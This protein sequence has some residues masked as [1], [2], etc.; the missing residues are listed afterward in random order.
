MM[1]D[2]FVSEM[3]GVSLLD[4]YWHVSIFQGLLLI[5][6]IISLVMIIHRTAVSSTAQV[7][8]YL[9][10]VLVVIAIAGL[11][12]RPTTTNNKGDKV[13]LVTDT[14]GPAQSMNSD[15]L[16]D[17]YDH[18]FDFRTVSVLDEPSAVAIDF[19]EQLIHKAP[20]MSELTVVGDGMTARYWRDIFN[21]YKSTGGMS[22]V[23]VSYTPTQLIS[24]IHQPSYNK[25]LVLGQ[26]LYIE[27]VVHLADGNLN[28]QAVNKFAKL[29]LIDPS[30]QVVEQQQV[31]NDESFQIAHKPPVAG[32]LTYYLVLLDESDNLIS[33]Q[34]LPIEVAS[35]DPLTVVTLLSAPSFESRAL[36]RWLISSGVT[37]GQ[38]IKTSDNK[39]I[40][41]GKPN[42]QLIKLAKN[43][44]SLIDNI[45]LVAADLV[46]ID[47]RTLNELSESDR[48]LLASAISQGLGVLVFAD[49]DLLDNDLFNNTKSLIAPFN[50]LPL[51]KTKSTDDVIPVW[52]DH[53]S[54]V[55]SLPEVALPA[56]PAAIEATDKSVKLFAV[57]E[58]DILVAAV[59]HGRG[60][61]G[62]TTLRNTH[63]WQTSGYVNYFTQYWQSLIFRLARARSSNDIEWNLRTELPRVATLSEI[64]L[65][66][67]T[68]DGPITVNVSQVATKQLLV[69]QQLSTIKN[70][71]EQ[72]CIALYPKHAGWHLINVLLDGRKLTTSKKAFYVYDDDAWQA[73]RQRLKV[74]DS[75]AASNYS[76]IAQSAERIYTKEISYWWFWLTLISGLSIWWIEQKFFRA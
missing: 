30:G 5:A 32:F 38:K 55:Q 70:N 2:F 69:S 57:A 31:S 46:L 41:Q 16:V 54:V 65:S 64:C 14:A 58:G 73:N 21:L 52:R 61:Y 33:K 59:N 15:L 10:M 74:T 43:S 25:D 34:E 72:H 51:R 29:Q 22:S 47:G 6:L 62:L 17:G 8:H 42:E 12:L 40:V 75:E 49:N 11:W 28:E 18:T 68:V 24:G 56:I 13:L 37:V 44:S 66:H 27:G 19:L 63:K 35:G 76:K 4:I 45:N 3:I 67:S 50:R 39:F 20:E 26:S 60:L 7:L 23:K 71:S 9:A 1:N 53:K 36:A 48:A